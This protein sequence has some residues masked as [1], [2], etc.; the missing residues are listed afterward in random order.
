M[1]GEPVALTIRRNFERPPAKLLRAFR[2]APT[3]FVTDAYNGQGCLDYR[4]KPIDLKMK[5]WGPALTC[6]C[7]P[8]DNLAAMDVKLFPTFY[9]TDECFN[10]TTSQRATNSNNS[11]SVTEQ[12]F[13]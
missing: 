1:I 3:G 8:T 9:P 7:S 13:R 10:R 6:Y 12:L 2:G 4:I 5:V 11:P